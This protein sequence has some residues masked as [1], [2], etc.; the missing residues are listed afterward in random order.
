MLTFRLAPSYV[1][2]ETVTEAP[3]HIGVDHYTVQIKHHIGK[4]CKAKP[5]ALSCHIDGL[6][7]ATHYTVQVEACLEEHS[8]IKPCSTVKVGGQVWTAPQ[9]KY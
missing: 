3:E 8:G 6:A 4:S 1:T 2:A 7:P 5:A 9:C